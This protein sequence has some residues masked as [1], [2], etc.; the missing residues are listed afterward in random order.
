[1][2]QGLF[3]EVDLFADQEEENAKYINAIEAI[4]LIKFKTGNHIPSVCRFLLL[5]GFDFITPTH[6]KDRLGRIFNR[7]NRINDVEFEDWSTTSDILNKGLENFE[8]NETD[9]SRMYEKSDYECYYWLK[10]DF[11]GFGAIR[12]LNITP[13]DYGEFLV[14]KVTLWASKQKKDNFIEEMQELNA[15]EMQ[16]E[17]TQEIDLAKL[18]LYKTPLLT[19]HEAACIVSDYDPELVDRCRND[20]NF[21]ENFSSYLRASRFLDACIGAGEIPYDFNLGIE[22]HH[23]KSYLQCEN[24]IITGFNDNLPLPDQSRYGNPTIG[25]ASPEYY[26]QKNKELLERVEQL[27][28]ELH[29]EKSQSSLLVLD[30]QSSQSEVEKLKERIVEKDVQIEKLKKD[31]QK[32]NGDVFILCMDLDK[33][34]HDMKQLKA[35]IEQL[36]SE[37]LANSLKSENLLDLVF[38]ES[39]TERYAPDLVHSIRLWE[40]LY[41]DN[42]ASTDKHSNR[43]NYWI[44]TNTPY[45]NETSVEVKRLREITSPFDNWNSDRKKKLKSN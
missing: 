1:M 20:T 41:V 39:R 22:A 14:S 32:E 35:K 3:G 16:I 40:A 13:D 10:S 5:K 8:C 19:L 26:Q 23:L 38:D 21:S 17:P 15:N 37:Q 42:T 27:E 36:E 34:K 43:S 31:V 7:D 28:N 29:Q 9:Y 2:E 12:E 18:Y 11:F 6:T 45:K 33:A 44:K 30:Y 24:I 25:H 4:E